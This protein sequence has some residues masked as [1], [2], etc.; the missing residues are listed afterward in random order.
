MKKHLLIV[1]LGPVQEF[2]AQARRTRDLWFGSHVLSELSRAAARALV[3]RGA[4]LVF[5]ALARGDPEL[6][7]CPISV[8]DDGSSPLSIA[9]KL[10]S[11]LPENVNPET[12]AREVRESVLQFWRNDV[13][14]TVKGDCASVLARGVDPVWEEQIETFLEFAASWTPV[15]N[16]SSD[17]SRVES[18]I[19]ARKN[20]RDFSQWK[21]QRDGKRKSSLDGGRETVLAEKKLR[22]PRI[23]RTYRIDPNEELDAVGLVKRAGGKPE[24]FVPIVNVALAS[25]ID[26]AKQTAPSEFKRLCESCKT[27]E[28]AQV[29]RKLPCAVEF[30]FD[31]SVLLRSRWKAVF[32]EQ[33]LSGEPED[34]G[35]KNVKPL[36]SLMRDPYPYVACL[37]ADGDRI[38]KAIG[39]LTS[40][41]DHRQFS[42]SLANFAKEARK[43][44][45][46]LH[47]GSLVYAGGDDV[48]AF[49]P[50][51]EAVGCADAL[52]KSFNDLIEGSTLSVGV[53]IG[54]V[55][56][57][58][59]D[60]LNLGR[61]AESLAKRGSPAHGTERNALAIIVSKRSGGIRSWRARW[62]EWNGDPAGRLREDAALLENRLSKRKIY[63]I[64]GVLAGMPK[65]T[66][67]D[68]RE[69][70]RML[71]QEVRRTLQRVHAGEAAVTPSDVDLALDDVHVYRDAYFAVESWLNRMLIAATLAQA[72]PK[73]KMP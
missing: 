67:A 17:R 62:D 72:M 42:Q 54:H 40:S 14:A 48:L 51:P 38:G 33:G 20:L 1:T 69:W 23:A 46:Q 47:R 64:S 25:W 50:L 58:M 70:A 13:A 32:E 39:T 41:S 30:P 15:E 34:W 19:A 29:H 45:E 56:E 57:S 10:V 44:V 21:N 4:E 49:L 27:I 68:A 7:A 9:N 55:M 16:Y 11:E 59:G 71:D 63:E 8:R 52:R 66:R 65:P 24:Q 3:D 36:L 18:T 26:K 6:A 12:V 37:V 31:A 73:P 60:L 2:I 5:P 61:E 28:L 53:G 22:D 35:E 43:I